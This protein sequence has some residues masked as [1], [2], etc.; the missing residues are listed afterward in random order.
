MAKYINRPVERK[1]VLKPLILNGEHT[2]RWF[3]ELYFCIPTSEAEI[4]RRKYKLPEIPYKTH[5]RKNVNAL[6]RIAADWMAQD[7]FLSF[8]VQE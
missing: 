4:A 3:L 5:N 7:A 2:G 8:R 6:K 1:A